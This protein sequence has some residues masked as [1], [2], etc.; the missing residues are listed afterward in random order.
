MSRS[1]KTSQTGWFKSVLAFVLVGGFVVWFLGIPARPDLE[2]L[3]DHL[4]SRSQTLQSWFQKCVP[5][6]LEFDFSNCDLGSNVV[7]PPAPE[8]V[9]L[10][11][12]TVSDAQNTL[13]SLTQGNAENVSYNRDEWNHWVSQGS[14]CWDTRD[15]VLYDEAVKDSTLVL[16]NNDKQPTTDLATACS[17]QSGTWNDPYSGTVIT[18]PGQLDVDHMIPLSYAANHGG[19][20]WDAGKKQTYANDLSNSYHLIAVKASENRSKGDKGPS[21]WKPTNQ[22]YWCQYAVDWIN[23]TRNYSLTVSPADVTALQEMLGTCA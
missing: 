3:P 11:G 16:L 6:I 22:A 7:G 20:A 19:Q 4:I 1:R 10:D 15:Q 23:I 9:P 13:N 2:T 18:D 14:G 8:P 21:E 5:G 17:I 12:N